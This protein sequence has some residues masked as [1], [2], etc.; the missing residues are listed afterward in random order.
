MPRSRYPERWMTASRSVL[1]GIVPVLMQTPPITALRSMMATRLLSLAAWM[2]ARCPAGPEPMTTM[3]YVKSDIRPL[4]FKCK[5]LA[6][7]QQKGPQEE[8]QLLASARPGHRQGSHTC[9]RSC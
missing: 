5:A 6:A 3:S 9:K 4:Q 2:A 7:D 1:L 8:D